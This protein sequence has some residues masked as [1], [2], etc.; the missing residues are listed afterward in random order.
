[1]HIHWSNRFSNED[2]KNTRDWFLVV[3]G[4]VLIPA[5]LVEKLWIAVI[6]EKTPSHR[7]GI[8]FHDYMVPI[9]VD[10]TSS[11]YPIELWNVHDALVKNL[12]RTNNYR[13]GLQ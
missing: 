10:I 2:R 5:R 3:A 13:R 1:M 6:D 12:P 8:K 11:R 9:Y 7:S 4:L